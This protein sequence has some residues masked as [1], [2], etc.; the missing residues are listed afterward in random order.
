MKKL[1]L[2]L[3]LTASHLAAQ[4]P[5]SLARKQL[6]FTS[7]TGT[8]QFAVQAIFL[9][10]YSGSGQ[11][12][13]SLA[14]LVDPN[15]TGNYAYTRL[16]SS[17][18]QITVTEASGFQYTTVLTF[19]NPTIGTFVS[20]AGADRQSGTFLASDV[21][22]APVANISTRVVLAAGQI[23]NPGFVVGGT[24]ARRVLIRAVGPT[25]QTAFNVSGVLATPSVAVFAGANQIAQNA[26]WG[27]TSVLVNAFVSVGA[28]A[29]PATS[30]DAALLLTLNPGNYTAQVGGGAGDVLLEIY[31]V[32]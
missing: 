5:D 12:F 23:L 2:L 8:G 29:L 31:F 9:R 17:V 4:A 20:T 21:P 25:L 19:V 27:G 13:T 1:L 6:M 24:V 16:T 28:F 22:A 15:V 32:D 26:G 18:G 3:V 11:F 7:T 14:V 30:R 10:A